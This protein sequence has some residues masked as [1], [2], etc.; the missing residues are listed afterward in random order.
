MLKERIAQGDTVLGTFVFL[1]S[2]EMVEIMALAGM[3]YIIIDLEHSPKDWNT[4]SHMIRAANIH[5]LPAL[6]RVSENSEKLILQCLEIGA[7]G[8]V[9]PFVQSAE[10]VRQAA[11]AMH[12]PPLG[13][14]GTCTLTRMT[15][16]GA[17]RGEFLDYCR[18]QNERLVLFGQ[19]ED[20]LGVENIE[21]ILGVKPGLDAVLIGRSD[22]ASSLGSPGNVEAPETLEATGKI[23][24][25]I[26]RHKGVAAAMGIYG[27]AEIDRWRSACTVFF[28]PS[29]GILAFNAARGWIGDIKG[30]LT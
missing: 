4:V 9:I 3:D 21:A 14:R 15:G 22:L 7:D 29:D 11:S 1:S 19:V 13:A 25:A 8:L 10:D 30:N 20:R 6:V 16:F 17:R 24:D 27:A 12:Y 26:A 28:A 5:N 2:P 23:L 18:Q